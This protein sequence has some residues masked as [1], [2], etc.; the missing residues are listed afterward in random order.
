MCI[1]LLYISLLRWLTLKTIFCKCLLWYV[2]MNYVYVCSTCIAASSCTT[3]MYI[4]VHMYVAFHHRPPH[5]VHNTTAKVSYTKNT[6]T[7]THPLVVVYS[8][9]SF[10]ASLWNTWRTFLAALKSIFRRF[11]Y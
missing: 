10:V 7:C 4:Q 1:S 11:L 5:P 9:M 8:P 3:Y 6:F 2:C